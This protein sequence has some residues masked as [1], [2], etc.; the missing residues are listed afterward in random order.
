MEVVGVIYIWIF[1]EDKIGLGSD[2]FVKDFST[3]KMS[4]G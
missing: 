3:L 4:V 1:Q 2:G